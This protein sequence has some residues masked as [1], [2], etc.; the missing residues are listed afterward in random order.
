MNNLPEETNIQL[1]TESSDKTGNNGVKTVAVILAVVFCLLTAG[2]GLCGFLAPDNAFSERE[3]RVLAEKPV[4]TREGLLNGSYMKE[5]ETYLSDQF[6]F[7]D[8]AISLKTFADRIMGKKE[9]NGVYIGKDGYLFD[10]Q[11]EYIKVNNKEKLKA[12]DNFCNKNKSAKQLFVLSPN[13]SYIYKELLPYKAQL[14]DQNRQI[15]KIFSSVK[16][17]SLKK[18][19]ATDILLEAKQDGTQL[20]YK[21][22]HHWTTRAAYSV[23]KGIL[24]EWK[25][26][27]TKTEYSFY[28]VTADFEGTLSGKAGISGTKD[29]IEICVPEKAEGTYT[30]N[31][32]SKQTKTVSLF[33]ES[34]LNQ[35]N[36]YEVF[37]GGNF[38]KVVIDTVTQNEKNLLIIKDSYANC[39][40]PMFTPYFS[41]IV[42]VDPRYLTDSMDAVMEETDFTHILFLYNLNTFLG[43]TSIVTAFN[44]D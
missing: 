26:D 4:L 10:S 18:L 20:F 16:S 24:K 27:K 2:L 9:E 14:P 32:E 23:F 15:N 35:K 19:N 42:I 44:E 38:D 36:K 30:V 43:D 3:N 12:I 41:K 31:Y 33:D 21:T 28:P 6:P 5:V 37:I 40:I 13:S 17:E 1:N 22:D 8:S 34:K 7:R 11:T 25:T 39:M 29:I